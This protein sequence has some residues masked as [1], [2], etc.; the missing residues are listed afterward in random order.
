MKPK[1]EANNPQR[2]TDV[3][4]GAVL[5]GWVRDHAVLHS[6]DEKYVLDLTIVKMRV[7]R[8]QEDHALFFVRAIGQY[9]RELK[10][11][12]ATADEAKIAAQTLGVKIAREMLKK[13]ESD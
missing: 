2:P 11:H 7:S 8:C 10:R 13:L 1:L 6:W 12:F 4:S 3:A 9:S 5:G